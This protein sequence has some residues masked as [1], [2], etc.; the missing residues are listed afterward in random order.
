[1]IDFWRIGDHGDDY[2]HG[3]AGLPVVAVPLP[4]DV[5][6]PDPGAVAWRLSE[7]Y[8]SISESSDS[9]SD[10]F[11]WLFEHVDTAKVTAIV[12]GDWEDASDWSGMEVVEPLIR[13]ADRLPALRSLFLGAMTFEHCELSWIQQDDITP[14]LAAFPKLERLE[15]RGSQGLRLQPMRH[16]SLRILRYESAGLPAEVV[17]ATGECDLPALEH[18][19]LWFGIEHQGGDSTAA[20]C[21]AILNGARLPS[22]RHLGLRN[23]PF[24]D[25]LAVDLAH[26]PVVARLESLSL[27][28]GSLG[29]AGAEAL[30]SGQPLTHLRM[31]HLDHHYLSEAMTARLTAALPETEVVL[32]DA[33]DR[34]TDPSWGYVAVGE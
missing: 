10:T 29:D 4:D 8:G 25:E 6:P 20:D 23:C 30:L 17:R 33:R 12:I 1:M 21:A 2:T 3:Y 28:M 18:L 22:L 5:E 26:A 13:N 11:D 34:A 19:E 9:I 27:S 16:E 24:T 7:P 31:L 15:V 14:L 32:T